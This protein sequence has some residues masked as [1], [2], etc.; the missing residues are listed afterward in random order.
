MVGSRATIPSRVLRMDGWVATS[1]S[2]C[3]LAT[4]QVRSAGSGG[5]TQEAELKWILLWMGPNVFL[6]LWIPWNVAVAL[7]S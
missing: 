5:A 6:C 7:G 4:R 2:N 1:H 3:V